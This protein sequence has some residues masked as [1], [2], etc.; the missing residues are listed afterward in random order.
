[1]CYTKVQLASPPVEFYMQIGIGGY[2][3][4]VSC[5]YCNSCSQTN[6][7]QIIL[8]NVPEDNS[9]CILIVYYCYCSSLVYMCTLMSNQSY[10]LLYFVF[11]LLVFIT[12]YW[13]NNVLFL[14]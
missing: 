10:F 6:S 11:I 5:T 1:M 14:M 7:L 8:F 2:V 13:G 3:V 9:L 12:E 4:C